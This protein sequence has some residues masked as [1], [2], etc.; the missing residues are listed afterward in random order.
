MLARGL[1]PPASAQ[2]GPGLLPRRTALQPAGG[3]GGDRRWPLALGLAAARV[4]GATRFRRRATAEA[5]W[6]EDA[7]EVDRQIAR[8]LAKN[9]V[10]VAQSKRVPVS[11]LSVGQKL[12]GIVR[13]VER[14]GAFV[15]VGAQ[16]DGLVP[17]QLLSDKYVSDVYEE[18][19][20][21]Q[22][23]AVW[24][25]EVKSNGQLCLT[26]L[27]KY[28]RQPSTLR[29]DLLAFRA[30]AEDKWLPGRVR[31]RRYAEALVEVAVPGQ[32][33]RCLT[34]ILR[35]RDMA[36]KV[37]MLTQ[38]QEIRVRVL[39][40]EL[41]AQRL[42]FST[43]P[44]PARMRAARQAAGFPLFHTLKSDQW[45]AA[46]VQ[47]TTRS[48]AYLCVQHPN[49]ADVTAEGQVHVSKMSDTPVE[50]AAEVVEVGQEIQVRILNVDSK[51]RRLVCSMV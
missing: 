25:E 20:P 47:R 24:V 18:I 32:T 14:F 13:A 16:R 23:V 11:S 4:C 50:D 51:R 41:R 22:K 12:T 8:L 9:L 5:D 7:D 3:R 2:G 46:E 45:L 17:I 43:R 30:L 39:Q 48:E 6:E 44:V 29:Q 38:G 37:A 27:P 36:G 10:R 19:M 33:Q 1:P 15:D 31:D 35:E 40:V 42:S 26:M 49:I 21:G 34:G 28:L